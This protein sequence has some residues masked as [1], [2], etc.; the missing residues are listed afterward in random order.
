M[1]SPQ[2]QFNVAIVNQFM[3]I[4]NNNI[5]YERNNKDYIVYL[6]YFY[7]KCVIVDYSYMVITTYNVKMLSHNVV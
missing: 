5:V 7:I 3:L 2:K 6:L 4:Y 1:T